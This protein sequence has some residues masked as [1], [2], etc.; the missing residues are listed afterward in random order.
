[1][2]VI[3]AHSTRLIV[4]RR[5]TCTHERGQNAVRSSMR[6]SLPLCLSPDDLAKGHGSIVFG[7][8]LISGH[9]IIDVSVLQSPL[10]LQVRTYHDE[11]CD[12]RGNLHDKHC[13][14]ESRLG[15]HVAKYLLISEHY[16][17]IC[18]ALFIVQPRL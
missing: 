18:S 9:A 4:G 7:R 10:S 16:Y 15:P 3:S 12:A 8:P 11:S 17:R 14:L 5:C 13:C 2:R 1:M 6:I